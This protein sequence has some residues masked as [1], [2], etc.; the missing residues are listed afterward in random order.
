MIDQQSPSSLG[1]GA[2]TFMDQTCL[3]NPGALNQ[4]LQTLSQLQQKGSCCPMGG[5]QSQCIL[6][7]KMQEKFN[8][9]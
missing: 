7:L 5:A 8:R 1:P 3:E 6:G 9:L 4:F 2:A